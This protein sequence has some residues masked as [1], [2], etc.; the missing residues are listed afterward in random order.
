MNKK[1][2]FI[3]VAVAVAFGGCARKT[4]RSVSKNTP[5]TGGP[6]ATPANMPTVSRTLSLPPAVS[7]TIPV[8]TPE[9]FSTTAAVTPEI[10]PAMST[11]TQ[12]ATPITSAITP[13]T[14]PTTS[15]I[16]S[17][18]TPTTKA[19]PTTTVGTEKINPTTALITPRATPT[20]KTVKPT[21]EITKRLPSPKPENKVQE[22][23]WEEVAGRITATI[24]KE[25]DNP[26]LF[27]EQLGVLD[28][29]L[30]KNDTPTI[31]EIS[32]AFMRLGR[33]LGLKEEKETETIA[34]KYKRIQ[35]KN[36]DKETEEAF[37]YVYANGIMEGKSAG[38]YSP[39]RVFDAGRKA[40]SEEFQLYLRRMFGLSERCLLGPEAQLLRTRDLPKFAEYYPYILEDFPNEFYDWEFEWMKNE[41]ASG[42]DET[43]HVAPKDMRN[44]SKKLGN[45]TYEEILAKYGDDYL[46][47]VKE[48]LQRLF[49]V[50][51]RTTPD[52][53]AWFQYILEH[54]SQKTVRGGMNG[55]DFLR[56]QL[57]QYLKDMKENET[58]V[59]CMLIATDSS[60]FYEASQNWYLRVYVKYRIVSAKTTQPPGIYR[61][62]IIFSETM[63]ADFDQVIL[64]EWR[65]GFFDVQLGVASA[66][67]ET[68]K[69]D[70]V[71]VSDYLYRQHIWR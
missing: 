53:R 48:Y 69:I 14:T 17:K 19:T 70:E 56:S 58:K 22:L 7:P 26:V 39:D 9:V 71:F 6:S 46:K 34:R 59:E 38:M 12:A 36:C 35:F 18:G 8:L 62:N 11:I 25:T 66:G 3:L 40:S 5:I 51:Y 57:E 1:T 52:D 49:S 67:P 65:D 50:D 2:I 54:G 30:M 55:R 45:L 60:M 13:M 29:S 47:N 37:F 21:A 32:I 28:E 64:G 23:E 24:N 15:A 16:T 33:I 68:T 10:T 4:G 20:G 43:P 63:S 31:G 44:S 27:L 61:N 41:I 42:P